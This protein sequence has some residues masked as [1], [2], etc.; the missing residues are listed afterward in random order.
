MTRT[1]I[2]WIACAWAMKAVGAGLVRWW[3]WLNA[4][5][6]GVRGALAVACSC[7]SG[8][9]GGRFARCPVDHGRLAKVLRLGGEHGNG[10]AESG[11][12]ATVI[13]G[14]RMSFG[15]LRGLVGG[16][17]RPWNA[18][19]SRGGRRWGIGAPGCGFR[20]SQVGGS[21]LVPGHRAVLGVRS[22][23]ALRVWCEARPSRARPRSAGFFAADRPCAPATGRQLGVGRG[24]GPAGIGEVGEA[25][26]VV[27]GMRVLD[28]PF[29]DQ[30]PD[31]G[32]DAGAGSPV[33]AAEVD[34]DGGVGVLTVVAV[35]PVELLVCRIGDLPLVDQA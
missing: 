1:V 21:R 26:F 31:A 35:V 3:R 33:G 19:Y 25:G 8:A 20:R 24:E 9:H 15:F 34:G 17:A 4:A 5:E 27:G 23:W 7:G 12:T 28:Q 18:R 14:L 11:R 32:C 6:G 2:R 10:E 16:R 13:F 22:A 29:V 30:C